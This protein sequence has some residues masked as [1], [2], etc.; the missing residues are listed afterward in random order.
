[1]S[2]RG[3]SRVVVA[4][5]TAALLAVAVYAN[6]LANGLV[7]DDLG[8]I[9]VNRAVRDPLDWR[10]I[11]LRPSWFAGESRE[12]RPLTTWTFALNWAAHG[13]RPFGYHLANVLGHAGVSALVVLLAVRVG[14]PLAAAAIAG[15]LFALHPIHTEAVASVVGR[16]EI[17]AAALALLAL[18]AGRQVD[19]SRRPLL[20]VGAVAAAYALA[21][22]AKEHVVALLVL[23]PLAD[24]LLADDGSLRLFLRRL[25]GRRLALYLALGAITLGY[26]ALRRAALGELIGQGGLAAI[27]F[28][29]N[30][31]ASSGWGSRLLTALNVE[32]RA[33][34]LLLIPVGLS[35]DYSYRQIPVLASIAEPGAILGLAMAGALAG[36]ALTFWRRGRRRL[37]FW[38]A[39]AWV[40]YLP[41]S[42]LLLPIGTILGERL[43]YLPS[44]GFCAL[45]ATA[46]AAPRARWPRLATG[47][48]TAM[49]IV[50]FAVLTWRRNRVWHDDLTLAE[51]TAAASPEST[52]AHRFLGVVYAQRGRDAEALA[53]YARAL[54]IWPENAD[55]LNNMGDILRRRGRTAEARAVFERVTELAPDLYVAWA[56]LGAVHN[57]AGRFAEGLV[58]AERALALRPDYPTGHVVRGFALRGLERREEARLAFERAATRNPTLAEPLVGLAA[59]A[60]DA[61]DYA[62]SARIFERMVQVAPSRDAWAGL[63]ESYR[64]AGRAA[65]AER[66][67]RAA[68][69]RFP[70]DPLFAR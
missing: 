37:L 35:A 11:V 55:A 6:S 38:L 25:R 30:P 68:A 23:V 14:A 66:A 44:V 33:V 4:A 28:W 58:T 60:I 51:A 2:S 64:R 59:L 22:A 42:N 65:E 18:L 31:A 45:V 70:E 12:H 21:L 5:A 36:L 50:T 54:A 43:L 41:V 9:S 32:A 48:V 17:L 10:G 57:D 52:Q 16:A 29:Q 49:L 53:A 40:P 15:A 19:R 24:L 7:Y 46:L 56:N 20:V 8:V 1:M 13:L 3:W 67:R 34:S 63:V 27:S 69:G 62:T 61:G 39:L 47:L 26:L